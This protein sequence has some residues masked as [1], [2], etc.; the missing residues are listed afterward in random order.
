MKLVVMHGSYKSVLGIIRPGGIIEVSEEEAAHLDPYCFVS[1]ET[2]DAIRAAAKAEIQLDK[3][4]AVLVAVQPRHT[5]EATPEYALPTPTSAPIPTLA[6]RR[7]RPPKAKTN[8][9]TNTETQS[10]L[11]SKTEIQATA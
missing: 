6:K 11:A 8:G 1:P 9:S 10:A 2:M 3:R 5:Q 7:G 4:A